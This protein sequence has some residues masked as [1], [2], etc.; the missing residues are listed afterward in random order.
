MVSKS[1]FDALSDSFKERFLKKVS[2][3]ETVDQLIE[4]L[5]SKLERVLFKLEDETDKSKIKRLQSQQAV[6]EM[7][8]EKARSQRDQPPQAD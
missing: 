5:E 1:F 4:I 8:I 6:L 7:Q 3:A 2:H